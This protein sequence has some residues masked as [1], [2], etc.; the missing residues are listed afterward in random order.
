MAIAPGTC[1][2]RGNNSEF[3]S[4]DVSNFGRSIIE[5]PKQVEVKIREVEI[6]VMPWQG[7]LL[8]AEE[9][10]VAAV[11]GI[12]SGKTYGGAL[13]TVD[14]MAFEA[15]TGTIGAVLANTYEQLSQATLPKLW[16]V[17]A[18]LGMEYGTD[19]VQNEAP[20]RNWRG[21]KS[22]FKKHHNVVSVRC[23]GQFITR[24]LEKYNAIRGV[25]LGWFW[26]DEAR[27]SKEE[28]FKVVL[29]RLRCPKAHKREG[30]IT[31]SP[32]GFDWLYE[33]FVENA[34]VFGEGKRRMIHMRTRDNIFLDEEFFELLEK[35]YDPLFA[36]QELDGEFV[37]L[38][39]G[40]VYRNFQ[41]K[42]HV[43]KRN[44]NPELDLYVTADWNRNPMLWEI[45]QLIPAN[46]YDNN[47]DFEILHVIDE[48]AVNE[49]DTPSVCEELIRRYPPSEHKGQMRFC[50][51]PSGRNKDTR[52]NYTDYKLVR[53]SLEAQ[54]AWAGRFVRMWKAAQPP[55]MKR[56]A[57]I[58]AI[59]LNTRKQVRLYIDPKCKELHRDFE[60][61]VWKP[62]T[63][64]MDKDTDRSRTHAS[65]ALS[66]L[67]LVMFPP[68]T[69][70]SGTITI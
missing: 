33:A 53:E 50:G 20:P 45:C 3:A 70:G 57:S 43:R 27:D 63:K 30:R 44:Y 40:R 24:S 51:D 6:P 62:G 14:K 47:E 56:V 17:F 54:G 8:E 36:K 64:L 35:S 19:Y 55:Q 2:T 7:D 11:G 22:R 13:Y 65:D 42:I 32:N 5:S 59:L 21:F 37:A 18:T 49:A 60:R 16:E 29:G 68:L 31:T 15:D 23:W 67:T 66:Y 26:W 25:E 34:E 39:E 48:I 61:C 38:T 52:G 41:R 28:A 4:L 10:I 1:L 58:N 12:G 46:S 9:E 69:S